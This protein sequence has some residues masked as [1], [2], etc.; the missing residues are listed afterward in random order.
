M[1]LRV[2]SP[3]GME[4]LAISSTHFMRGMSARREAKS[5]R[6]LANGEIRKASRNSLLW[7]AE[8]VNVNDNGHVQ[9]VGD[10]DSR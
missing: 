9:A 5:R 4:L 3:K 10:Y 8:K 1:N 7:P 2:A 6:T